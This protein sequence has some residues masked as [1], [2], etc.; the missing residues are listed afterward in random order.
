MLP[1]LRTSDLR[2]PFPEEANRRLTDLLATHYYCPTHGAAVNLLA[3]RLVPEKVPVVLQYNKRDLEEIQ[4][5]AEM[6]KALNPWGRRE[7][8]A[9][10]AQGQGVLETFV[11]VVR[12]FESLRAELRYDAG[13]TRLALELEGRKEGR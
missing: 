10:A 3:N 7:F 12:A 1:G 8:P 13:Q 2:R 6:K 9:V 4:S 5:E 11:A